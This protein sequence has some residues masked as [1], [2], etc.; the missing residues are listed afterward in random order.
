MSDIGVGIVQESLK[1]C[2][3]WVG[4]DPP[5]PSQWVVGCVQGNDGKTVCVSKARMATGKHAM[6]FVGLWGLPP[7]TPRPPRANLCARKARMG[8]GERL[9]NFVGQLEE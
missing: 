6:N 4:V 9:I 2:G 5:P 7:R 1:L 3:R 8:T